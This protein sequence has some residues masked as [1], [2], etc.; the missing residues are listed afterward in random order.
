MIIESVKKTKCVVTA[1]EHNVYGGLGESIAGLLAQELPSPQE[2]VAVQD[3]FGESGTPAQL[4][5]KY[6]L[7]SDTIVDKTKNVLLRK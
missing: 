6:G 1:E 5:N 7:N 3:S 4:I 2:Y